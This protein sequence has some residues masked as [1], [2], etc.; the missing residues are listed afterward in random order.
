MQDMRFLPQYAGLN[1][2]S[3]RYKKI[4]SDKKGMAQTSLRFL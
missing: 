3:K 2:R 1:S 4:I